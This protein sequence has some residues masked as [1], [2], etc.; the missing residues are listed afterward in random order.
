MPDPHA[1]QRGEH[2]LRELLA[3][4]IYGQCCDYED[5]NYQQTFRADLLM[6]TT[7]ERTQALASAPYLSRLDNRATG[8]Q[9]W[10][11]HGVLLDQFVANQAK[12]P[13][14]TVGHWRPR[15]AAAWQPGTQ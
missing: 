15:R 4:R 2:G 12:A 10:A 5:L 11:L 13:Q 9:A 8:A 1:R 7:V 14:E 6:Q 3:Q